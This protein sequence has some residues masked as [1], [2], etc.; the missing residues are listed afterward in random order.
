[1]VK[2]IRRY[3][4]SLINDKG[5]R[6]LLGKSIKFQCFAMHTFCMLHCDGD[7]SH[8]L[9]KWDIV[10]GNIRKQSPTIIW[11]SEKPIKLEESLRVVAAV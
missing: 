3:P 7:V 5:I 2:V 9:G 4:P 1:M 8:C 6:W 11:Q 10:A